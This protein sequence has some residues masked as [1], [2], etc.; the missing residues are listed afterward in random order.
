MLRG[1]CEEEHVVRK[2]GGGR[3][4]TVC[5]SFLEKF[6][7]KDIKVEIFKPV[8]KVGF[9]FQRDEVASPRGASLAND[10]AAGGC[11]IDMATVSN[12]ITCC[13]ARRM[14]T[15]SAVVRRVVSATRRTLIPARS[16]NKFLGLT[17]VA[18]TRG[19]AAAHPHLIP[20]ATAASSSHAS[21]SWGGGRGNA[22]SIGGVT[23][24]LLGHHH[25]YSTDSGASRGGDVLAAAAAD[26]DVVSDESPPSTERIVDL[27]LHVEASQSYLAYAMSVIV[28][29]AL[30]DVRDGGGC[31]SRSPVDP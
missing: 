26:A 29:R 21:S 28:G 30:P 3:A 27:E 15:T 11:R 12:D 1:R 10:T 5:K 17:P 16:S 4:S 18:A 20:S 19:V 24:T 23:P 7:R 9:S 31:A 8:F 2:V 13:L 14:T 6:I 25:R 22:R